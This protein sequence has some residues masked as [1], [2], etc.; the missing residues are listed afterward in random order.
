MLGGA[1]MFQEHGE[2]AP[3]L[4]CGQQTPVWVRRYEKVLEQNCKK[5]KP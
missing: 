2:Q 1:G 4:I 3:V 5:S